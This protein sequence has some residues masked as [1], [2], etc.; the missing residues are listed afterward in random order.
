MSV[1]ALSPGR[2]ELRD[3]DPDANDASG[4]EVDSVLARAASLRFPDLSQLTGAARVEALTDHIV[5]TAIMRG[6]LEELRLEANVELLEVSKRLLRMP[7]T[8]R[9][10]RAATEEARRLAAPE[11]AS[12][13]DQ[14]RWV[15]QRC[16]EQIN[17]LGGSDYDAA[18][19]AYTL[20]TG[21]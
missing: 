14:A 4:V 21:S 2:S 20:L 10:S 3:P 13:Q 19:R 5:T 16:T 18:S 6:E 15:T 17:R 12:K 11:L 8:V 1:G 9:G 7:A